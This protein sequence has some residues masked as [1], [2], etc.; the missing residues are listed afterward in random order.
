MAV[1]TYYKHKRVEDIDILYNFK[2]ESCTKNSGDLKA[3]IV[4]PEAIY[5]SNFSTISDEREEKLEK[6]AHKNLVKKVKEV[7]KDVIE[8]EIYCT[9]FKDECP[10]CHKLQSWGVSGLKKN[11]FDT[12]KIILILGILMAIVALIGH[13][14]STTQEIPLSITFWILGGTVVAAV[15]SFL[16]NTIKINKR[17][18]EVSKNETRN[19]PNIDWSNIEKMLD[20]EK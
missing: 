5:T 10:H 17:I 4:G 1:R 19:T 2:C 11:K 12:P 15:L 18:K 7:Y 9:E 14:C 6:D 20:E 16:W 3:H 8:K 13:Y